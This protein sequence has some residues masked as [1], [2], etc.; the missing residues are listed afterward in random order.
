M[1]RKRGCI[2]SIHGQLIRLI[3]MSP[4]WLMPTMQ[5]SKLSIT[6]G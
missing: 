4:T 5:R 2:T 3:T 6:I 1:N